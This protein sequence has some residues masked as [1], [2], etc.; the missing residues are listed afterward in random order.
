MDKKEKNAIELAWDA[1]C[2]TGEIGAYM[3]YKKLSE[4]N[5]LDATDNHTRGGA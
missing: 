4:E 5:D 1:F 2:E 3:L